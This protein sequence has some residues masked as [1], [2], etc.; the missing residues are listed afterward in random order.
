MRGMTWYKLHNI[1]AFSSLPTMCILPARHNSRIGKMHS[2][3][4]DTLHVGWER[5]MDM[6]G[7]K[8]PDD[9]DCAFWKPRRIKSTLLIF[10]RLR[11]RGK[12][13]GNRTRPR[14]MV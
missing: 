4:Q 14:I 5:A 2:M 12:K 1:D 10:T 7:V 9:C 3:I 13:Y 6:L 8:L 11:Y